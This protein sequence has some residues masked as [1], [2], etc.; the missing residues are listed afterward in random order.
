MMQINVKVVGLEQ[1]TKRLAEA[2]RKV[3]PVLRG[4]LNTTATKA[5]AERYVKGLAGSIKAA[6]V[7]RALKVKRANSRH[8]NARI[9]PSSAAILVANYQTWGFGQI[10]ATRAR[11]WVRGPNGRKVAAGFVNPASAQ[12]LP[13]STRSSKTRGA[14]AYTYKRALQLAQGPSAAFWFKRLTDSQTI[15]WVN[16]YLQQEFAKRL[17]KELSR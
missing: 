4:A 1:A 3:D 10:D 7:R 17:R 16:S 12:Q 11:I 6:R 5:R 2:G 9:I 14:K 13:W 15:N 8:M